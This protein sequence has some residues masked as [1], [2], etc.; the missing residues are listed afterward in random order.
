M[1]GGDVHDMALLAEWSAETSEAVPRVKGFCVGLS[2][3]AGGVSGHSDK[4]QCSCDRSNNFKSFPPG[5][6]Q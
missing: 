5:E 4:H 1:R 2:L 3:G 6:S